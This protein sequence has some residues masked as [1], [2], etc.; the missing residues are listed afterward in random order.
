MN[1]NIFR[2][3]VPTLCLLGVCK[4]QV[5]SVDPLNFEKEKQSIFLFDSVL[6]DCT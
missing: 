4:R 2:F 1:R 6:K 3:L 5:S